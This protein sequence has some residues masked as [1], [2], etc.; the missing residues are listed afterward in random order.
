MAA[1]RFDTEEDKQTRMR[2][3]SCAQLSQSTLQ[4]SDDT[5]VELFSRV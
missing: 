2:L 1:E 3:L 4:L 5:V